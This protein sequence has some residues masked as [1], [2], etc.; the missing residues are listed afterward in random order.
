MLSLTAALQ[1]NAR[2]FISDKIKHIYSGRVT[3]FSHIPKKS[4][5]SGSSVEDGCVTQTPTRL[6]S[7]HSLGSFFTDVGAN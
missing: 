1:T 5:L 4:S 7:A 6:Q 2:A 3:A